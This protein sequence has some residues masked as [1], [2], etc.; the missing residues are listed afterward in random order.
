MA[1]SWRLP[2]EPIG[3]IVENSVIQEVVAG[4]P[5]SVYTIGLGGEVDSAH[6]EALG[7]SGAF[8]ASNVGE[9]GTAFDQ[10]AIEVLRTSQNYYVVGYCSPKRAGTHQ[11]QLSVDGYVGVMNV[12][13]ASDFTSGCDAQTIV[14]QATLEA[15]TCAVPAPGGPLN[16]FMRT[17]GCVIMALAGIH[18]GEGAQGVF[19]TTEDALVVEGADSVFYIPSTSTPPSATDTVQPGTPSDGD[20]GDAEEGDVQQADAPDALMILTSSG[21]TVDGLDGE[22]IE[23]DTADDTAD[24]TTTDSNQED[25]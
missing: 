20:A 3:G 17:T 10:S 13:D 8:L 9:L 14:E 2:T 25:Q 16:H 15:K 23:T 19:N 6:L 21:D 18:C 12:E 1:P 5:H 11:L 4:T 7:K 24:D 22:T